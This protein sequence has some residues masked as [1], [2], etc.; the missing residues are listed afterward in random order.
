MS[1]SHLLK[2]IFLHI[3]LHKFTHEH[4]PTYSREYIN[5]Y[6]HTCN[7]RTVLKRISANVLFQNIYNFR[8]QMHLYNLIPQ[9]STQRDSFTRINKSRN[10]RANNKQNLC[11]LQCS[12]L[13]DIVCD[14]L[15][16]LR[17]IFL[18]FKANKSLR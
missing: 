17:I 18:C 5:T 15:L 14:S 4:K 2:F 7:M 13:L 3:H 10:S 8:I 6:L 11:H 1:P 12:I 9:S 16:F